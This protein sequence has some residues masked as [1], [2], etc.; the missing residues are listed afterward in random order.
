MTI[1]PK[2]RMDFLEG[3]ILK[4]YPFRRI[5]FTR[6]AGALIKKGWTAASILNFLDYAYKSPQH[7]HVN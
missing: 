7:E 6:A 1:T 5:G 4:R 3:I 2:E